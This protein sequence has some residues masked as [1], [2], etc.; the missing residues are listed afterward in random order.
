[1][2]IAKDLNYCA[3]RHEALKITDKSAIGFAE[4]MLVIYHDGG[5]PRPPTMVLVTC[6]GGPVY[7]TMDG[8]DPL[9]DGSLGHRLKDGE[10]K[11]IKNL[12]NIKNFRA[13]SP[14]GY[15][16]ILKV[17]YFFDSGTW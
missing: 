13:I 14:K 12:R 16:A 17:T 10:E 9:P 5:H 4:D 8:T 3:G 15:K 1:M 11:E 2:S 7:Y 6:E